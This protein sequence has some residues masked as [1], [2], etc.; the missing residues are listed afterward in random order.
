MLSPTSDP[1][2]LRAAAPGDFAA[3]LALMCAANIRSYG[4][5]LIAAEHL[6]TLWA[7]FDLAQNT[8]VAYTPGGELAGYAELR[9]DPP[10][11]FDVSLYLAEGARRATLGTRLLQCVE[12]RAAAA[13]ANAASFSLFSRVSAADPAGMQLF[14]DAGYVSRLSFLIMERLL[15]EPPEPAVWPA[16]VGVRPF[17]PGQDEQAVYRADEEA[18]QDKGYHTPLSFAAWAERMGL[19]HDSF[20]P[21][22]WFLADCNGEIAGAALNFYLPATETAWVDHLGVRRSWRKQGLGYALLLH[23]LAEFQ[24]RGIPRARLSVDSQSLTNAPRLY[25]RAGL[26]TILEYH[27]FKKTCPPPAAAQTSPE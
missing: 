2:T 5:A 23:S 20:D 24:R 3:V 15:H 18:S 21:G 27:I 11:S 26:E 14:A 17:V 4:E 10:D 7:S 1:F 9:S 22:L 13:A 16:G 12:R 25:A 19:N 8:W 6:Q